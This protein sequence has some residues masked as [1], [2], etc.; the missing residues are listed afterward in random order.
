MVLRRKK[1]TECPVIA[2]WCLTMGHICEGLYHIIMVPDMITHSADHPSTGEAKARG[3]RDGDQILPRNTK[4]KKR[5]CC[6]YLLYTLT[7]F[8]TQMLIIGFSLFMGLSIV[9][10]Y[11]A[12]S[13]KATDLPMCLGVTICNCAST[14]CD[15]YTMM[16]LP[17]NAFL[18][19]YSGHWALCSCIYG[20]TVFMISS[21]TQISRNYRRLLVPIRLNHPQSTGATWKFRRCW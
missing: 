10:F 4:E 13:L 21:H 6:L 3:W 5:F 12:L 11:A 9:T 19:A 7:C 14:C 18:S 8:D 16:K 15:V 17:H 1:P 20:H 2:L